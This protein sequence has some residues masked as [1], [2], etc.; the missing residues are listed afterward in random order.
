MLLTVSTDA[1]ASEKKKKIRYPKQ[2]AQ[3][4]KDIKKQ[5]QQDQKRDQLMEQQNQTLQQKQPSG[6]VWT[7]LSPPSSPISAE[8]ESLFNKIK[9]WSNK[10]KKCRRVKIHLD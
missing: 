9:M 8:N 4:R 2:L 3:I 6:Y 7:E 5:K 1:F 10:K